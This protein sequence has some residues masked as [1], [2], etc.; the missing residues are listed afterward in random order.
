MANDS[1]VETISPDLLIDHEEEINKLKKELEDSKLISES[2]NQEI[3]RLRKELDNKIYLAASYLDTI[4]T[5]NAQSVTIQNQVKE[6]N[7]MRTALQKQ[8]TR[9]HP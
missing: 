6:I 4:N 7:S 5:M 3:S 1:D 9:I 2:V 8:Q